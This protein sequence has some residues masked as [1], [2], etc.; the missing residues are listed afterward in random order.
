MYSSLPSFLFFKIYFNDRIRES[1]LSILRQLV[2]SP[3]GRESLRSGAS[4]SVGAG[5]QTLGPP[6]LLSQE[7][8][9][10][11]GREAEQSGTRGGCAVPQGTPNFLVT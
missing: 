2:H 7:P 1:E 9:Q 11:A 8:Q 10:G 6:L 4:P 5:A 3:K